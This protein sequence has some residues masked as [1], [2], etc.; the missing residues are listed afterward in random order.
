MRNLVEITAD[1]P[2]PFQIMIFLNLD[3]WLSAVASLNLYLSQFQQRLSI[4][5]VSCWY[6][7]RKHMI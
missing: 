7:C 6:V 4:A 5:K 1:A 3:S 2:H